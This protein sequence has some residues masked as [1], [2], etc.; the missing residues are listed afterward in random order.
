LSLRHSTWAG[1]TATPHDQ[2]LWPLGLAAQ[3]QI[4]EPPLPLAL[5]A[6]GP[7]LPEQPLLAVETPLKLWPAP[8]PSRTTTCPAWQQSVEVPAEAAPEEHSLAAHGP[9]DR[10]LGSQ[11]GGQAFESEGSRPVWHRVVDMEDSRAHGP[12]EVRLDGTANSPVRGLAEARRGEA[13][14]SRYCVPGAVLPDVPEAVQLDEPVAPT[15]VARWESTTAGLEAKGC[16]NMAP[17]AQLAG[18]LGA[19]C[20]ALPGLEFCSPASLRALDTRL[21]AAGKEPG[22]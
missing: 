5:R 18:L 16:C 12:A 10:S 3:G 7:V 13:Q 4:S 21:Q 14:G 8:G 6:E 2:P 22:Y 9:V 20:T 15:V 19:A 17:A 1:E 11:A